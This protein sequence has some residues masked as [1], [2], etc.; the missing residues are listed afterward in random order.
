MNGE[1]WPVDQFF[2]DLNAGDS[3]LLSRQGVNMRT[4][5]FKGFRIVIRQFDFFPHPSGCMRSFDGF[6]I[7]VH[8]TCPSQVSNANIHGG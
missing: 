6:D 5:L 1:V 4:H 7:Q 3:T 2:V 8:D